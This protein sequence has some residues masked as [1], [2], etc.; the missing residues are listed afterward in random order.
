MKKRTPNR[1]LIV[2]VDENGQ[3][4]TEHAAK[5]NRK[6][7]T[8]YKDPLR[9]F[10]T[11]PFE[12]IGLSNKISTSMDASKFSTMLAPECGVLAV[13]EPE[14]ES[15]SHALDFILKNTPINP[16]ETPLI[17]ATVSAAQIL[18]ELTNGEIAEKDFKPGK[19]LDLSWRN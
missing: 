6:L 12:T 15:V 7:I 17:F 2:L 10:S 4:S 1:V 14:K 3:I 18:K 11:T 16:T 13:H 19:L 9:C 8:T 5:V